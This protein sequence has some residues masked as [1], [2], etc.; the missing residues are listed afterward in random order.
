MDA[1]RAAL[2]REELE[3]ELRVSDEEHK[4]KDE[5]NLRQLERLKEDRDRSIENMRE[6]YRQRCIDIDN[7]RL[8]LKELKEKEKEN[9]T[10]QEKQKAMRRAVQASNYALYEPP[11][12]VVPLR[13]LACIKRDFDC[14]EYEPTPASDQPRKTRAPSKPAGDGAGG[15]RKQSRQDPRLVARVCALGRDGK[16]LREIDSALHAEGFLN[17]KGRPWPRV[18]SNRSATRLM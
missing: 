7:I 2:R 14:D 16:A 18:P 4:R 15:G 11:A 9:A 5:E 6:K 17:S 10:P 12:H 13:G 8:E 1:W 3:A